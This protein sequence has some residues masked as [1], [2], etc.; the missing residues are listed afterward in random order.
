M[1]STTKNL[2]IILGLATIAFAGY[3]MFAQNTSTT[4]DTGASNQSF[5]TMLLNTQVFIERR[6]ELDAIT[7]DFSIFE[8]QAFTSLRSYTGDIREVSLSRPD[9]F[10]DVTIR[11]S[12]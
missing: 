6:Q 12:F 10:A 5:E 7:L 8:D 1:T 9:P 2:L 4:L 3:F 11:N